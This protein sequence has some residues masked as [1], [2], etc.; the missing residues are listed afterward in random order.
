MQRVAG[1]GTRISLLASLICKQHA[2]LVTVHCALMTVFNQIPPAA[3]VDTFSLCV[4][5][6]P[7]AA[8]RSMAACL[9]PGG[10]LLLLEHSRSGFGPLAAYQ[11]RRGRGPT[12]QDALSFQTSTI[13]L[14]L[15]ACFWTWPVSYHRPP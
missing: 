2:L 6:D 7:L 8:L 13:S 10:T 12:F 15:S 1:R 11:V 3:V 5:P 9:K 14:L 4:F